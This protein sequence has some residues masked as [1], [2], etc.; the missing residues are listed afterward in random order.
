MLGTDP[1]KK[2]TRLTKIQESKLKKIGLNTIKDILF[3]FPNRYAD[4]SGG[5]NVLELNDGDKPV[6]TGEIYNIKKEVSWKSKIP[7]T[8]AKFKD[9]TGI[10]EI[11]WLH[12]P[13]I[14]KMLKDGQKITIS[15]NLSIKN[16]KKT[17]IN[18]D[19]LKNNDEVHND[20]FSE[21]K[22]IKITKLPIYPETRGLNAKWFYYIIQK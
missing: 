4:T 9:T 20:L 11:I 17:I 10:I 18:P 2:H 19:V 5:K 14:S 3:Y 7:M 22:D 21:N 16:N 15:G 6:L 12:Q 1:I 13:Y 8:R